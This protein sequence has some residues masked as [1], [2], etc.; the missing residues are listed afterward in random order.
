MSIAFI[1]PNHKITLIEVEGTYIEPYQV[2]EVQ[3]NPGQRVSIIL[4]TDQVVDNYMMCAKSLGS[5]DSTCDSGLSILHYKG[6]KDYKELQ[7]TFYDKVYKAP[8]ITRYEKDYSTSKW[9]LKRKLKHFYNVPKKVNKKIYFKVAEAS[10]VNKAIYFTMDGKRVSKD[11]STLWTEVVDRTYI[12]YQQN[13]QGI[14]DIREGDNVQ[15]VIEHFAMRNNSTTCIIHPWHLHGH[16]YYVVGYGKDGFTANN[17]KEIEE[18]LR[19]N[20]K[21]PI[22]RDTFVHYPDIVDQSQLQAKAFNL[23]LPH[24]RIGFSERQ[25][26]NKVLPNINI[27]ENPEQ[28]V[29]CGWYAIRFIANNPGSWYMHC[30]IT[31]HLLMGKYHIINELPK[32]YYINKHKQ[33]WKR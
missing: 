13:S 22:L 6:A 9:Y 18:N 2:S 29:S 16:S 12:P 1:I 28:Y 26:F 25:N 5:K 4:E 15:I 23:R 7:T 21:I 24:L 11:N 31:P 20:D 10:D 27:Q 33:K 14:V 17:Q 30:H 19:Y 3:I 32:S 8:P